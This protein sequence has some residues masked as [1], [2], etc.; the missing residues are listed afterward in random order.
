MKTKVLVCILALV[1][2]RAAQTTK[3]AA[4]GQSQGTR[5]E[6]PQPPPPPAGYSPLVP[7]E[8]LFYVPA[9]V[10]YPMVTTNNVPY[11][12]RGVLN[13]GLNTITLGCN[14]EGGTAVL[15]RGR[16]PQA[17]VARRRARQ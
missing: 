15:L 11:T 12:I 8:T 17:S 6:V 13:I 5:S 16:L 7:Y 10:A 4:P 9:A 1:G 3:P 2:S 14:G